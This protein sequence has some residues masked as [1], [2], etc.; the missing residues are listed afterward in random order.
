MAAEN[1]DDSDDRSYS[2][3]D[4]EISNKRS[5]RRGKDDDDEDY[6]IDEE[7]DKKALRNKPEKKRKTS[8]ERK[9]PERSQTLTMES[10]EMIRI[11]RKNLALLVNS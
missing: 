2:E 5:K 3:S 9:S 11:S 4:G 8:P 7:E 6:V 1:R 10:L